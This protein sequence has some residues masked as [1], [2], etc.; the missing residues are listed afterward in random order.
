MVLFP[1]GQCIDVERKRCRSFK[2]PLH[3]GDGFFDAFLAI[4]YAVDLEHAK[5]WL[6]LHRM[7][8]GANPISALIT[9]A[10]HF[11]EGVNVRGLD[12]DKRDAHSWSPR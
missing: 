7:I 8:V 12:G 5:T 10:E 6:T 3:L 9:V 11:S 1:S 4:L 2:P